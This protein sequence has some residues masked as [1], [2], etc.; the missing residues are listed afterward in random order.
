MKVNLNF[1]GGRIGGFGNGGERIGV[2]EETEENVGGG[3]IVEA[4]G[5]G[6][7]EKMKG[8]INGGGGERRETGGAVDTL[9]FLWDWVGIVGVVV[10]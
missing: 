3:S 4:A 6:K 1:I 9:S 7:R 2:I 8:G 10:V 5:N